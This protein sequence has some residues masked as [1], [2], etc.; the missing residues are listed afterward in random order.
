L[1]QRSSGWESTSISSRLEK[2]RSAP[3]HFA[4]AIARHLPTI[5]E[6]YRNLVTSFY[7][8]SLYVAYVAPH[9]GNVPGFV[10]KKSFEF[11]LSHRTRGVLRE[12]SQMK[13][14]TIPA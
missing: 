2:R 5:A 7:S 9:F 1:N 8:K 4:A 3:T 6:D 14:T 13:A 10:T 11:R 12:S